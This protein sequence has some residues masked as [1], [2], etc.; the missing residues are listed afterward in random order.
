MDV[1]KQGQEGGRKKSIIKL[2]IHELDKQ[3]Q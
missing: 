3:N 2:G 1:Q